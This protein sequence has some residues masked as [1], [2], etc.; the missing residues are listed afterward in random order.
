MKAL[1]NLTFLAGILMAW[2]GLVWWACEG[3]TWPETTMTAGVFMVGLT[4][5]IAHFMPGLYR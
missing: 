1:I 5:F 3:R 2:G 4:L